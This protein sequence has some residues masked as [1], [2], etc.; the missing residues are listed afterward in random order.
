MQVSQQCSDD[1]GVIVLCKREGCGGI[2]R[3]GEPAVICQQHIGQMC[4]CPCVC[5]SK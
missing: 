2:Y 1:A 5:V 3:G 4:V